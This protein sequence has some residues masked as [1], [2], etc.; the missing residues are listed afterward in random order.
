MTRIKQLSDSELDALSP[1]AVADLKAG[2]REKRYSREMSFSAAADAAEVLVAEGDSWF[3]FLP[4]T[5]LIDCLESQEGFRIDNFAKAGDTLENMIFGTHANGSGVIV[6]PPINHVLA[7]LAALKPKVMLFSGGGNDVVGDEFASYLNHAD[8][9]LPLLRDQVAVN[10]IA[11]F[12]SYLEKLV[13]KVAA[14]SPGTKVLIHGYGYAIP[15]GQ[16]TGIFGLSFVGPWMLPALLQ[17]G[18][19]D[20]A[21]RRDVVRSLIDRYNTMLADLAA[22]SGGTL[23][24]VDLRGVITDGDWRDELHLKNSAYRR[25]AKRI[26]DRIRSIS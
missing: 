4:G 8:S 3:D 21:A 19:R 25:C 16:G 2:A 22:A 24:Y 17:K 20:H 10:M 15:T 26:A 5:D 14:S 13:A 1:E 11:T 9:G 12:R 18:V 23:L 6:D 7:R